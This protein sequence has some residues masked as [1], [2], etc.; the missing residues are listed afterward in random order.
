[1]SFATARRKSTQR[2]TVIPPVAPNMVPPERPVPERL[3]TEQVRVSLSRVVMA[4]GFGAV[5]FNVTNGAIYT[6]FI[7]SLSTDNFL[8]GALASVLPL[9]S[10]LQV[11]A[12]RRVEKTGRRKRQ[13]LWN[14]LIGR[15]LWIVAALIPL[16]WMQFP[17][18]MSRHQTFDLV[19]L[20]VAV[21]AM[22]QAF[23]GPAFFA[24][25][26]DLIPERLR[27]TFFARRMQVG[28]LAALF[29]SL[30]VGVVADNF[31]GWQSAL[32]ARGWPFHLQ[33]LQVY[34][35]L[36]ALAGI[37]GVLDIALFW[38]VREPRSKQM[39]GLGPDAKMPPLPPLVQ[40]L[41][42]PL[43]DPAIRRFLMFVSLLMMS[44]GFQGPFMWLHALENLELSKT[45][46]GFI[47]NVAPLLGVVWG[48][49]FWSGVIKRYGTRPVM[50]LCSIGL[51]F[52]PLAWI[53]SQPGDWLAL[54]AM[55]FLSGFFAG[56][57]DLSNQTLMM[58]VSPQTPRSTLTALFSIAAG[59]S[60]A[61]ATLT[62]G[63]LSRYL[64]GYEY[65]WHG[66]DINNYQVCFLCSL[67]VRVVNAAVMAPRLREPEAA[68]TMETV[69]EVVPELAQS[70]ADLL[71]RPLRVRGE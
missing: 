46:T 45:A 24:W 48:M 31:Q 23:T 71:T 5:F 60:F 15:S 64:A 54:A 30:G 34:C 2:E 14:G 22:F 40:S 28:T 43:R 52:I 20:C 13:M 65:S 29:V 70:F 67:L 11:I 58:G 36:M 49:S 63:W 7:R 1:M 53:S 56:A 17:N 47:A 26:A 3:P 61:F 39:E 32:E 55:T 37:C 4:W 18:L 6:V 59:L 66:I 25:M 27:S 41:K 10:F 44:Y 62:G 19:L 68:S 9:M 42:E 35:I 51:V 21:S 33:N 8:Y 57:I 50:R 69:K 12:A 16:F 38:G